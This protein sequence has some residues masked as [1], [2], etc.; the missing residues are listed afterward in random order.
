MATTDKAKESTDKVKETTLVDVFWRRVESTPESPAVFQKVNGAYNPIIWREQGRVVELAMGGLAKL[1]LQAGEHMSILSQPCPK[2]TWADLATISMGA[3]TVPVYPT[4]TPAEVEYLVKHSDSVGIFCENEIQLTKILEREKL[5]EKLRFAV[6]FNGQAPF[7]EKLKILTWE[8]LLKDG[9]VYLPTHGDEIVA[10]RKAV[11]A[12]DLASIVYTSGTTGV[13]KGVMISHDNIF[14]VC[15]AVLERQPLRP[16]D[17]AL[18]FLPLSHVYE[19]VGGQFLAIFAGMPTAYAESME[20]VPKNMVEVRPTIVNGVPRFYEK[21][22]Q[23]I[24]TEA[25]YLPKAQQILIKWALSLGKRPPPTAEDSSIMRQLY[26]AELRAADR[27][28]Y[29]KIRR[30]FGGRLRMLVSGA[31]PLPTDVQKFFEILGLTIVE[32]YGLTETC[33]PV[34]CNTPDENRLGTVGRPL[35]GVS[36]KIAEDGELLVKGRTVFSGYY[37]NES[38]TLEAFDDGWFKTGDIAEID[39]DGFIKIKDRKKDI[40]ITAGG[41]HVAPQYIENLFKGEPLISHCLVY[42]DRRKFI[43]ALL[44]VNETSLKGFADQAKIQ[45]KESAELHSHPAV[46]A[47]VERIVE[48]INS[49][50]ANF[51]KIKRF[52]ILENDFSIESDEL[53]PTFKVKRKLVTEKYRAL[54]DGLYDQEDLEVEQGFNKQ[55]KKAQ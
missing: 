14:A 18:S 4:L 38:A 36:V 40:I 6:L 32:G 9:E 35:N 29:S 51:E 39:A 43:T 12:S 2:W 46:R 3:V 49:G 20:T 11:K 21:A 55:S 16:T 24:I 7:S 25:R 28:V 48:K 52:A 27:L 26:R 15:S 31:A 1:G 10:R 47:E 53:T 23:R 54:L 22:Y 41:K 33:A 45:Y 13:P 50:L 37:K 42:G 44:T 8:D 30:R 19:R 5:P 34:A 17:L